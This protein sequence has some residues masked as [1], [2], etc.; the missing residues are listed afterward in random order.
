[1]YPSL[2][3]CTTNPWRP[4][5]SDRTIPCSPRSHLDRGQGFEDHLAWCEWCHG[6]A[7]FARERAQH[8]N[9]DANLEV[10]YDAP[11]STQYKYAYLISATQIDLPVDLVAS[12]LRSCRVLACLLI[13]KNAQWRCIG[14]SRRQLR[15]LPLSPQTLRRSQWCQ[16]GQQRHQAG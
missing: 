9:L 4:V 5:R 8:A 13:R 12:G 2:S 10:I 1:M 14:L 15:R 6:K 3:S 11:V 7:G 16:L